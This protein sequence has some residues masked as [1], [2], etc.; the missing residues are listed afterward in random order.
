MPLI[1][2]AESYSEWLDSKADH[3]RAL[4]RAR[5]VCQRL[6]L[7]YYASDAVANDV[8]YEGPLAIRRVELN[9]SPREP[10]QQL[11]FGDTSDLLT[12]PG[13]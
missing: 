10:L 5:N 11:L 12:K 2:P 3:R 9:E 4:D 13:R 8:H 1:V 7:E 6:P